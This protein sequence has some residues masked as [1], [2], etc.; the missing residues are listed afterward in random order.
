ME[1]KVRRA[2]VAGLD[3]G[4]TLSCASGRMTSASLLGV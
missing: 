2:V 3:G 4:A 1:L